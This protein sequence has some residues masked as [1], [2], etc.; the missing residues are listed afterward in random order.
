[1]CPLMKVEESSPCVV[2]LTPSSPLIRYRVGSDT[3]ARLNKSE[4]AAEQGTGSAWDHF[5]GCG[6][7]DDVSLA[8]L[9]MMDS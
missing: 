8:M 3:R 9:G 1:M 2:C 7:N 5:L 4:R 6:R